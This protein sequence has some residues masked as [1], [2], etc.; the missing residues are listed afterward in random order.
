MA[1]RPPPNDGEEGP[2][3]TCLVTRQRR[4]P[5]QMIRFVLSPDAVVTPDIRNRLPGRGVWISASR[6]TISEAGRRKVFAHG[7]RTPVA[8]PDDLV[9]NVEALLETD[10]LALLSL[11]NKA[12]AVVT[13]FGKVETAIASCEAAIVVH[14]SDAAADGVR[15]LGQT[16]RRAART[17]ASVKLFAAER[18]G[19]AL[20]RPHVIHAA[21]K[22]GA[23]GE[24]FLARCRRLQAFRDDTTVDESG[25]S[26]GFSTDE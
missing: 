13:G 7:F 4:A 8:A 9:A 5:G 25:Q 15:K 17:P 12:G 20:G 3:R 18:L 11:A 22:N 1:K 19:L 2:L 16:V 26:P 24:A 21:L 10:A 23:A 6:A 14:A